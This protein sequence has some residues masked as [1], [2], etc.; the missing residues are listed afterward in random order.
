MQKAGELTEDEL[1]DGEK[2][3]QDT[4]DKHVKRVDEMV[5]AKEKTLWK[6]RYLLKTSS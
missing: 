3:V 5:E 6:Y 2:Q 4:M 1:R